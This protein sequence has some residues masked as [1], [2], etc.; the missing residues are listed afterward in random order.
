[1]IVQVSGG[2]GLAKGG[3]ARE[4]GVETDEFDDEYDRVGGGD[5]A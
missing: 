1:M 2:D 5:Q 3:V 4:D